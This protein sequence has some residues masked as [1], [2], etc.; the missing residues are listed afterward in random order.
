MQSL[1]RL[2]VGDR[3]IID[4]GGREFAATGI[5]TRADPDLQGCLVPHYVDGVHT[6]VSCNVL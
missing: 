6:Q 4:L 2:N 3:L 1:H 5:W